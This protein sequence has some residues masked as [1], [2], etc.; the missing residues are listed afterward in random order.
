VSVTF[1]NVTV[2]VSR[3]EFDRFSQV[4][5]EAADHFRSAAPTGTSVPHVPSSSVH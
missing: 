1:A 3:D 2:R 5:H 4:V